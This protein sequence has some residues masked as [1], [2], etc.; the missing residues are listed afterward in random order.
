MKER[1]EI[2]DLCMAIRVQLG[3]NNSQKLQLEDL[4]EDLLLGQIPL[5]YMYLIT[6]LF[7]AGGFIFPVLILFLSGGYDAPKSVHGIILAGWVFLG[8]GL[9]QAW[10]AYLARRSQANEF[11][12]LIS[13][14]KYAI[15]AAEYALHDAFNKLPL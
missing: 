4:L 10:R 13:R 7:I 1:I 14:H 5:R 15:N 2:H 12:T 8:F 3:I 9:I 11:R 6:V